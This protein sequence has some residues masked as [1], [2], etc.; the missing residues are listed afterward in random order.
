MSVAGPTSALRP[1][2][3]SA[4]CS[5]A[6]PAITPSLSPRSRAQNLGQPEVGHIRL[7]VAV[8]KDVRRLEVAIDDAVGVQV[9]YRAGDRGHHPHDRRKDSTEQR[10]RAGSL[11]CSLL[12]V[13]LLR[14]PLARLSPSMYF[15]VKKCWP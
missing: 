14:D 11:R 12:P 3:C 7:L 13:S 9:L 4:T 15:I 1:A 10:A 8:Q 2:A 5:S 6:C